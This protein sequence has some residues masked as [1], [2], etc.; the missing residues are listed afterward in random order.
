MRK[1]GARDYENYSN[2]IL[3]ICKIKP[4]SFEVFVMIKIQ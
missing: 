2:Q 1:A 3:K 4:I